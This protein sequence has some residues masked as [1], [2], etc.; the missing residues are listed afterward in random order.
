MATRLW[1]DFHSSGVLINVLE[2]TWEAPKGSRSE[3]ALLGS[4][5]IVNVNDEPTAERRAYREQTS[6]FECLLL[7]ISGKLA[8]ASVLRWDLPAAVY[9]GGRWWVG[10][11]TNYSDGRWWVENS[12]YP[13]SLAVGFA[14]RIPER[15]ASNGT[16]DSGNGPSRGVAFG[17]DAIAGDLVGV[18]SK[19]DC[20]ELRSA[21]GHRAAMTTN[22][23]SVH[24]WARYTLHHVQ[25]QWRAVEKWAN[26]ANETRGRVGSAMHFSP[27]DY[28][29]TRHEIGFRWKHH[30]MGRYK[31]WHWRSL[32][33]SAKKPSSCYHREWEDAFADQKAWVS[34][35]SKRGGLDRGDPTPPAMGDTCMLYNQ[36]HV[37]YELGD[38][39]AI[40]YV[41]DTTSAG[42]AAAAEAAYHKA[43]RFQQYLKN[44]SSRPSQWRLRTERRGTVRWNAYALHRR[45]LSLPIV[46][47]RFSPEC[48][49]PRQAERR[50]ARAERLFPELGEN[51]LFADA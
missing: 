10:N 17:H 14:L 20:A 21:A 3:R 29:R 36:V 11:G 35:L 23:S 33:A 32:F 50:A 47:L 34:Y 1:Q 5:Y 43:V 41:N 12:T 46:Q 15:R 44:R 49:D 4:H 39:L 22:R 26:E 24:S 18:K 42:S 6:L 30:P 27:E 31:W 8:P 28:A 45:A 25:Q 7:K 51:T 9:S 16:W 48:Y 38:L 40:V 37:K 2:C 13:Y 19:G